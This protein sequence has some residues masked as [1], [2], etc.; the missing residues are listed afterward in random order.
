MTGGVPNG[1]IVF[2]QAGNI[3][4]TTSQGGIANPSCRFGQCGVVYNLT[5]S[6]GSWTQSVIYSFSGGSDGGSPLSG[7]TFDGAGNL[8]GTTFYGGQTCRYGCGTVYQ[9]TPTGQG[10]TETVLYSFPNVAGGTNPWGG[11]IFDSS[12]NLYGTTSQGGDF[13]C[14]PVGC[15]TVFS[16]SPG[17]GGWVYTVLYT[18]TESNDQEARASLFMDAVGNL[19]GTTYG[20]SSDTYG[21]VFQLTPSNGSWIYTSLHEFTRGA[22]GGDPS[23]SV[24]MDAQG[25]LYGTASL[26][27]QTGGICSTYGCGTVWEI[28]P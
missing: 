18:F 25:N 13:N 9:L 3:Y 15:G 1:G 17:N 26:W 21:N 27:G 2:D 10:W 6:H 19:Y 24:I 7:L 11:L 5:P 20:D 16:L 23:G 8:Y 12:G 28:T 4:G 14:V 22:D